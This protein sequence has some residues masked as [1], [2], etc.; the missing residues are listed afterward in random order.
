MGEKV[1]KSLT[2]NL[3]IPV[4]PSLAGR[5]RPPPP[6]PHLTSTI[7][8]HQETV[9]TVLWM[10]HLEPLRRQHHALLPPYLLKLPTAEVLASEESQQYLIQHILH[11]KLIASY[12]AERGYERTFWRKIVAE[13]EKGVAS[14][15]AGDP[16]SV[17]LCT[18]DVCTWLSGR[19]WRSMRSSTNT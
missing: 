8:L 10:S 14:I 13:L 3:P 4:L 7:L 9:H 6:P 19:N 18:V 11:D 2:D 17:S 5:D 1:C 16:D 15:Q 12:T